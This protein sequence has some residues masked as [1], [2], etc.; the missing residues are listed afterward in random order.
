MKL[1][2]T[3]LCLSLV[4][5]AN[6]SGGITSMGDRTCGKWIANKSNLSASSYDRTWLVGYMTGLAVALQTDILQQPDGE[7][8]FLWMDNWCRA[9]PLSNLSTGG[10]VLYNELKDRMPQQRH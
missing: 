10:T 1:K 4:A 6:S 3:V 2:A 7:S 8:I 5:A 9:N